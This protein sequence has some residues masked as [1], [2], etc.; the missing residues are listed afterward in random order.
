MLEQTGL[1][2]RAGEQVGRLSGGNRQRVN[3]AVGLLSDRPALLLDEPS[4]PRSTRS[5]A[6]GCGSSS[7]SWS[8]GHERA[9]LH[10]Q[11]REAERCARR[12]L[13]LHEGRLL[14]DDSPQALMQAAG[15]GG[16]GG[17][18]A[19]SSDE[20]GGKVDFEE[21]FVAFLQRSAT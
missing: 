9:V 13:V 18:E 15:G 2:D 12:V 5:S 11:P 4:P 17:G 1:A 7:P 10:P 21:G 19:G 14:F 20:A 3:I 8:H 16:G 6:N